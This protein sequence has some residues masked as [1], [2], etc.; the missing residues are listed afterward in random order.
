MQDKSDKLLPSEI[1]EL[2]DVLTHT[3]YSYVD[4]AHDGRHA[5]TILLE[6]GLIDEKAV[7]NLSILNDYDIMRKNPLNQVMGIYYNLSV[8]Y[9]ISVNSIRKI[10][11]NRKV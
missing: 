6:A 3:L 1:K 8:K 7:R 5:A 9:D 11:E 4:Q 10:V 2:V